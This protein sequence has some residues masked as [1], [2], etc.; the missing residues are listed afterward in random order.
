MMAVKWVTR[1]VDMTD[2]YS[3]V[4]RMLVQAVEVGSELVIQLLMVVR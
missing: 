4:G 3:V 2:R 1:V